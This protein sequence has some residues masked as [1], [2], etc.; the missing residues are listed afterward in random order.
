MIRM[1]GDF[2]QHG[3]VLRRD[4]RSLSR[5]NNQ[6]H[7]QR[8]DAFVLYCKPHDYSISTC[9]S[10]RRTSENFLSYLEAKDR[11]AETLTTT[12]LTD[13]VKTLMGYS[14]KMVE[15]TLCAIRAFLRFLHSTKVLQEDMSEHLPSVKTYKKTRIPSVWSHDEL[16]K[17]INAIDRGNPWGKRDYAMILLAVRLGLRCIDIKNLTF[18]DMKWG[19]N[20]IEIVQSKTK[21]PLSLPLL[22]DVGWA[23]IDYL[24]T[25]RPVSDSPVLFL[26]HLATVAPFSDEDHLHQMIVKYMWNPQRFI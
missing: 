23:I 2:Q 24:K 3:T 5:I 11:T 19:E 9:R 10:Y 14:S 16:S 25:G 15:F 21:D 22:K 7:R 26:R 13:F 12:S 20:R 18:S 4:M 8:F 17:R 1:L 6:A